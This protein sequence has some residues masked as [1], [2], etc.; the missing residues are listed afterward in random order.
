M[1]ET[2]TSWDDDL[3][4]YIDG[5]LDLAGR[6]AVENF[7]AAN[8]AVAARVMSD[9][10]MR[11]ALRLALD[12]DHAASPPETRRLAR[13]LE[14]GFAQAGM[15]GRARR[16]AAAVVLVAGGWFAGS[17]L[18]PFSV[19]EVNAS[20]RP[21][22]YVEEAVRA[23]RTTLVR[24]RM[25]SQPEVSGYDAD[26]IR[27]ATGIVMPDIPK[28]WR[29]VDVQVFP[30]QFGPSV[31]MS[32]V[33]EKGAHVS[34]FAVRPGFFAVAPLNMFND[35]DVEAAH[36]QIGEVAYAL[37]SSGQNKELADEAQAL[38]QSLY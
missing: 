5:Q 16:L 20:A 17:H 2:S 30:S 11:H 31:E 6:M 18:A 37:V 8:P 27:A 28:D 35:S 34:L 10:A 32:L 24:E 23:H 36:W 21:P 3:N 9:L 22:S 19:P 1:S 15:W 26:D 29:I 12:G 25:P 13:R 14:T 4:A 33:A 7:L 38:F